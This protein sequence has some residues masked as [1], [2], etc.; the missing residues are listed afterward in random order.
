MQIFAHHAHVMPKGSMRSDGTV[1]DLKRLMDKCGINGVVTFAPFYQNVENPNEWLGREIGLDPSFIAFGTVDM[2]RADV[3]DQVEKIRDMG[4]KGIKLHPAHQKFNLMCE[5]AQ[6]VYAKAEELGLVL[7][8]HTGIHWHRI[9]DYNVLL[10]D[11]IAYNFKKLKFTMEHVGGY[12]YFNEAV[13]VLCNNGNVYAGLTSVFDWEMNK[14]WYLNDKQL[15]D[16]VHLVGANRCIFGLDF[17]YNDVEKT[18]AGIEFIKNMR[19]SEED[20]KW[21][22]GESLRSLLGF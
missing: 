3:K 12:A 20:K 1:D 10:Y 8:F 4:F 19:I 5:R 9:K 13:G 21:I 6:E 15:H 16:L 2:T 14:Y 18:K 17:P 11:E 7:S 22:L